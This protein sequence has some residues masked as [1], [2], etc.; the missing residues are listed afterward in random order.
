MGMNM[1]AIKVSRASPKIRI[2]IT[3]NDDD[4]SL[5]SLRIA[6][7][8]EGFEFVKYT[9]SQYADEFAEFTF[10]ELLFDRPLGRYQCR[11]ILNGED[12][13]SFQIQYVDNVVISVEGA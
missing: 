2:R 10:D 3:N 1:N 4:L 11:L 6:R 12:R 5:L 9:P 13:L 7:V 8:G